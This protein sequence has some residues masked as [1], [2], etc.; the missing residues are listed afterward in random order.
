MSIER[1]VRPFQLPTITPPRRVLEESKT[2][3]PVT[4]TFGKA[5]SG[6]T[7]IYSFFEFASFEV[8]DL[9]KETE[10]S[11][12]EKEKTVT[13]PDD[14]EQKLTFNVMTELTTRA[15]LNPN[16]HKTYTFKDTTT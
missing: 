4:L 1:V 9:N 8:K 5:G 15:V 7:F 12:K 10:V 6:L 11:R 13:N 16:V 3:D 14:P 2:T